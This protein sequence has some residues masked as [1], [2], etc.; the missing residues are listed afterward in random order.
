M[1]QPRKTTDTPLL[2]KVMFGMN[3]ITFSQPAKG[4]IPFSLLQMDLAAA[5]GQQLAYVVKPVD[6]TMI[7]GWC[8]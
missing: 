6:V 2:D 7:Y 5:I 1:A 8:N 3:A 4:G